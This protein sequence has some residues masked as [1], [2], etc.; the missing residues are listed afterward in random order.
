[1]TL[2]GKIAKINA[3]SLVQAGNSREK[4]HSSENFQRVFPLLVVLLPLRTFASSSAN[5]FKQL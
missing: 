4:S 2:P 1:M 3:T 5:P